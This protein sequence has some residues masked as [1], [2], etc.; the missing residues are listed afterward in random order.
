MEEGRGRLPGG[1]GPRL[2]PGLR[3]VAPVAQEVVAVAALARG[4]GDE[5][6]ASALLADLLELGTR[7]CRGV[8]GQRY[9]MN[10]SMNVGH[11]D[12]QQDTSGLAYI[13][14][15]VN[16]HAQLWT[17]RAW[18]E[19]MEAENWGILK[20]RHSIPKGKV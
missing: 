15:H 20:E 18:A 10:F 6:P 8:M 1:Q 3:E 19:W 14:T 12:I 9:P 5:A 7:A 11:G 13:K 16:E 17:Y 4:A 2:V